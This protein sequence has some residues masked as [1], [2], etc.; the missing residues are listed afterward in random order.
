M[1]RSG[2]GLGLS[3]V[4]GTLKDHKGYI[5]IDSI[6]GKGTTFILYFPA[7]RKEL[8]K[9][10]DHISLDSYKGDGEKILVVDD[11]ESQRDIASIMLTKLGYSATVVSSGEKAIEYVK[12]NS[13]DLLVLDMIMDPGMDGLDTYKKILEIKPLQ[14]AIIASGFSETDRIREAQELGAGQYLK[15]PYTLEKMGMAVRNELRKTGN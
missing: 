9:N 6:E 2:T 15:K 1:G 14:K 12:N 11:M 13:V 5:D 8:L 10:K 4:W 7:T 3:V